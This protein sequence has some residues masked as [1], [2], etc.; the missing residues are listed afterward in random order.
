MRV[1]RELLMNMV[2]LLNEKS[3][4]E[5]CLDIAY[6]GYRLCR[7]CKSG[8]LSDISYRMTVR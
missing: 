6:G 8:G 3:N 4:Q 2:H 5:Y 7:V 1:T